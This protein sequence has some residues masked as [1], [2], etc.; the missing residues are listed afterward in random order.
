LVR[1]GHKLIYPLKNL[2]LVQ[3]FHMGHQGPYV[4][5]TIMSMLTGMIMNKGN[6][7]CSPIIKNKG[8]HNNATS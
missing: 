8:W 1:L 6:P 3:K 4:S 5:D 7:F 2:K